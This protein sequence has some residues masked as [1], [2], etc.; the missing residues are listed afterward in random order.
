MLQLEE[1]LTDMIPYV[2]TGEVPYPILVALEVKNK[3]EA[4]QYH[5]TF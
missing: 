5:G 2:E 1:K 4:S 3:L